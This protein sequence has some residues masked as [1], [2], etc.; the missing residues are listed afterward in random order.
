MAAIFAHFVLSMPGVYAW[1]IRITSQWVFD[2]ALQA[3]D[4]GQ[5]C[6]TNGRSHFLVTGHH[7]S[8]SQPEGGF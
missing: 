1:S 6:D 8:P 3:S 2:G 4:K 5:P 7:V